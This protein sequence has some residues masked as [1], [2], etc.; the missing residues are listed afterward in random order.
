[1]Y[2]AQSHPDI[3]QQEEERTEMHGGTET[4]HN[5]FRDS[6]PPRISFLSS[7]WWTDQCFRSVQQKVERKEMSGGKEAPRG[8]VRHPDMYILVNSFDQYSRLTQW[9]GMHGGRK[10]EGGGISQSVKRGK[11]IAA[12]KKL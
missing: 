4:V 8:Y 10:V 6:F 5:P 2:A 9:K 11:E 12:G 1:M 7:I 3:S